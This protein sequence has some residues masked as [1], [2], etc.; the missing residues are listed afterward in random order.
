METSRIIFH[1]SLIP[2]SLPFILL[3]VL[4]IHLLLKD[5]ME[6]TSDKNLPFNS[7]ILWCLCRPLC[8][9]TS[10]PMVTSQER[11]ERLGWNFP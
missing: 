4:N 6:F 9:V 3:D 1:P 5:E 10:N 8:P 7:N 2:K 11:Q